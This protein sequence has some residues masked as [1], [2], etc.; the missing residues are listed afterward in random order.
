MDPEDW[1]VQGKYKWH[2]MKCGRTQYAKR[3]ERG[4]PAAQRKSILLHREIMNPPE[5]I[6]VDHINGDGL[7][8]RRANLRL[9]TR[10]LNSLNTPHTKGVFWNKQRNK[11][12]ARIQLDGKV[13]HI[14][15]FNSWSKAR[16]AYETRKKLE[17]TRRP[18]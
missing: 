18:V 8:N 2:I 10:S 5:G 12:H 7:D 6:I 16:M 13:R 1:E 4:V 3:N 14:G 11:W 9:A 17:I 15:L